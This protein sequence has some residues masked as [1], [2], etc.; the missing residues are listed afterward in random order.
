M[1]RKY[2]PHQLRKVSVSAMTKVVGRNA[3]HL[4][5]PEA[6]LWLGVIGQALHDRDRKWF[7]N[8]SF[9]TV[10]S[11]IGLSKD[12][13]NEMIIPWIEANPKSRSS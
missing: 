3:T 11:F 10:A 13:A 7:E 12:S 5:S 6:K 8:G 2:D 4:D 9:Q 1:G